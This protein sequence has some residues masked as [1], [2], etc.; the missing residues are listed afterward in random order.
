MKSKIHRRRRA[1]PTVAELRSIT[2]K[3]ERR[4]LAQ[5]YRLNGNGIRILEAL[6][7]EH[8]ELPAA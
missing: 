3:K 2:T 5:K 4:K 7:M 6:V 1:F 8:T